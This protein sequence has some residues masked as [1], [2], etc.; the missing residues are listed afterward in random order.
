MDRQELADK[1]RVDL[2]GLTRRSLNL[3]HDKGTFIPLCPIVFCTVDELMGVGRLYCMYKGYICQE[4]FFE[5]DSL[6]SPSSDV[7]TRW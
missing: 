3:Y 5:T 7:N 2:A 4:K 6:R 1:V